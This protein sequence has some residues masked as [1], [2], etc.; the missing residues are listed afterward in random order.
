MKIFLFL[1]ILVIYLFL[2]VNS[3]IWLKNKSNENINDLII[4]IIM[5]INFIAV[6]IFLIYLSISA[7]SK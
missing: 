2:V 6:C 3:I 1:F 5:Y 7:N 4:K